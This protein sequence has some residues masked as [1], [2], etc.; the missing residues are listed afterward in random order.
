MQKVIITGA[1]GLVGARLCHD[2]SKD[3]EVIA[4]GG[5][6]SNLELKLDLNKAL[7]NSLDMIKNSNP[8]YL[9]HCA[10]IASPEA[11]EKDKELASTVNLKATKEI[12][13]ALANKTKLIHISTDLVFEDY[14]SAPINGFKE[15]D[16]ISFFSH[17]SY[18]KAESEKHVLERKNSTVIRITLG[19]DCNL[20]NRGYLYNAV[21]TLKSHKELNC[22]YDEYRTPLILSEL[23][24]AIKRLIEVSFPNQEIFHFCSAYKLSRFELGKLIAKTWNLNEDLVIKKSILQHSGLVKRARDVSLNSSKLRKLINLSKK[25]FKLNNFA[26]EL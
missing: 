9:I 18:T 2:L 19:L 16:K 20:I 3:F 8:D 24:E 23:S 7:N 17:Y 21:K 13:K 14:N 11:C 1:S 6:S 22:Y 12:C 4:I 5:P 25:D 10:A 15:D 26:I